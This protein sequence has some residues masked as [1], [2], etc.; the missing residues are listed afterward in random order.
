MHKQVT[1]H[2]E[3]NCCTSNNKSKH[4]KGVLFQIGIGNSGAKYTPP[5]R[6]CC[7][8]SPQTDFCLTNNYKIKVSHVQKGIEDNSAT[9]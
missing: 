6:F 7:V 3:Q 4:S 5:H 1:D 2:D 8:N 9:S